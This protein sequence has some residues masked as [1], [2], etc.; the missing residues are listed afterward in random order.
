MLQE[1]IF[2]KNSRFLTI[3][4]FSILLLSSCGIFPYSNSTTSNNGATSDSVSS[5][6]DYVESISATD[7]YT[8]YKVGDIYEQEA[9]KENHLKVTAHYK[10]KGDVNV[11]Y[12]SASSEDGYQFSTYKDPQN[13]N[14]NSG[15]YFNIEGIY[16]VKIFYKSKYASV[17]INVKSGY[18]IGLDIQ[19]LNI[20]DNTAS[21]SANSKF[22]DICDLYLDVTWS[23]NIVERIIYKNT[24]PTTKISIELYKTGTSLN[25]IND[26][27]LAS[28]IY[29]YKVIFYDK[30]SRSAQSNKSFTVSSGFYRMKNVN[31]T[32][33]TIDPYSR[34]SP[35]GNNKILVLP[36]VWKGQTN[37][38]TNANKEIIRKAYFGT[39]EETKWNS[40]KTYYQE[41]SYGLYDVDG[42]IAPWYTSSYTIADTISQGESA[43]I[44][45]SLEVAEAALSYF[46][47]N[48]PSFDFSQYDSDSDG[49]LDAVHFVNTCTQDSDYYSTW[50]WQTS[51]YSN[52]S[53]ANV[54]SPNL[55]CMA[56]FNI[57]FLTDL[58]GYCAIPSGGVNARVITH[59]H[60]H[61]IGLSDYYDYGYTGIDAVGSWDMQSHNTGD[62]NPFSKFSAGWLKPY[63]V[64]GTSTSFNISIK[65]S[66]L[67]GDAIV[68]P[69]SGSY[70]GTPFDEYLLIDFYTAEGL[71]ESDAATLNKSYSVY[72]LGLDKSGIRIYHVDARTTSSSIESLNYDN[73][74]K[75]AGGPYLL[76]LLQ[77]GKKNT[78]TMKGDNYRHFR[79]SD[80][81][82]IQESNFNMTDY[83]SFFYNNGMFDK[84]GKIGYSI[85]VS[86]ITST[87]AVLHFEKV[88]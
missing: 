25:V 74:Y 77:A 19:S 86:S 81:L 67:E 21:Y 44:N 45:Y 46:K 17:S 38:A 2:M 70:N 61:I 72:N 6:Q 4:L 51:L 31:K 56:W 3:S 37:K 68:V 58:D 41:T 22:L 73:D 87:N 63:V 34:T 26:D 5:Q 23:S 28:Q 35:I 12:K 15:A 62:W 11:S 84:G 55:N 13:N 66:A 14:F 9:I 65:S 36:I 43:S 75:S 79:T 29:D 42:Y 48:N 39:K 24:I 10:Y 82:F 7:S 78:F 40:L 71:N 52:Y 53:Y 49:Y 47:S 18:D 16:V 27:L 83:S 60:G 88:S 30:N 50:G 69:A 8:Q 57:D 80:D 32:Y 54:S 76:Q 1:E 59:E 20:V 64:D 33:S 85:T